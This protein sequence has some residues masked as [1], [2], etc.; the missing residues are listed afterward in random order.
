MSD[1]HEPPPEP[2]EAASNTAGTNAD[3]IEPRASIRDASGEVRPVLKSEIN[4][5][6]EWIKNWPVYP[7]M[8]SAMTFSGWQGPDEHHPIGKGSPGYR[9][10]FKTLRTV[11]VPTLEAVIGDLRVSFQNGPVNWGEP[12]FTN[13]LP[14]RREGDWL[15]PQWGTLHLDQEPRRYT[16]DPDRSIQFSAHTDTT[17]DTNYVEILFQIRDGDSLTFAEKLARGRSATGPLTA[18]LDLIY[19]DRLLAAV[20]TEEVGEVF[21][22]W[23]WNR[24]LSGRNVAWEG[25]ARLD[26]LDARSVAAA[27]SPIVERQAE[28]DDQG[29]NRLRVAAQWYWRA[30]RDADTSLRFLGYWLCIEALELG[31]SPN[32]APIKSAAARILGVDFS[33]VSPGIG[34]IYGLRSKIAHGKIRDVRHEDIK[35][36]R[37]VAT[38]LL[39]DHLLGTVSETRQNELRAAVLDR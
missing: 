21:P 8:P 31:D 6:D 12:R 23:H 28:R 17:P 38:A 39:E 26:F 34:R 11:V 18:A 30:D 20:I 32:I 4:G 22:D 3:E 35:Q 29:R 24:L 9:I 16:I 25:Q 33:D 27:I 2:T 5:L 14:G 37:A 7:E 10:V 36:V 19:G 15:V 1:P 13:A